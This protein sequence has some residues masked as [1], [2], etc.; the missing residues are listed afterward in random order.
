MSEPNPFRVKARQ[1]DPFRVKSIKQ[2]D[3]PFRVKSIQ[4]ESTQ[5]SDSILGQSIP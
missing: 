2:Q 4:Q 1:D 3:E 5:K